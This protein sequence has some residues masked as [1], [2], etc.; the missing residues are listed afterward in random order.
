MCPPKCWPGVYAD[1]DSTGQLPNQITFVRDGLIIAVSGHVPIDRLEEG[2]R[3]TAPKRLV[4][5]LDRRAP[6][7]RPG[8]VVEDRRG[9]RVEQNS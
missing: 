5:L 9:R 6:P 1:S 7:P 2:Y 4:A 3:M 8:Q